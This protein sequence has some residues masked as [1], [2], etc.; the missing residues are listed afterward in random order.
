MH[1]GK[2]M[3]DCSFGVKHLG[4]VLA[5]M[6][7]GWGLDASSHSTAAGLLHCVLLRH[8]GVGMYETQV[9]MESRNE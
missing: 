3:T 7:V 1:T 4:L 2:L 5:K 9:L 6:R 8:C